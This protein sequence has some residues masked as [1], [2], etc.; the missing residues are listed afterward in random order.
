MSKTILPPRRDPKESDGER[1]PYANH[2]ILLSF[3]GHL[4]PFDAEPPPY[5]NR[6]SYTPAATQAVG[7]KPEAQLGFG[8]LHYWRSKLTLFY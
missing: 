6:P 1:V 5:G 4:R 7:G 8:F 3:E 2:F